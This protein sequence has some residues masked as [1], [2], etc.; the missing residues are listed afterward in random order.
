MRVHDGLNIGARAVDGYVHRHFSGALAFTGN[1]V[2]AVVANQQI[3]GVHAALANTG[4]RG[5][6]AV[7][8]E[9]SR[10]VAIVGRNPTALI[11]HATGADYLLTKLLL[12]VG[13]VPLDSTKRNRE[14]GP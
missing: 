3:I 14:R 12:A 8:I 7:L 9:A 10:D 4:G 13:H 6:D 5:Q 11:H 2:A 1:T